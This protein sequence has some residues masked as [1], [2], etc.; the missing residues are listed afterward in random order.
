MKTS[1]KKIIALIIIVSSITACGNKTE[2]EAAT[3]KTEVTNGEATSTFKVWGNC[4]MC[5]ETIE[6]SLKVE[7]ITKADWNVDSKIITVTYDTTKITLDQIQ[8]NIASVG[9]D[10]EKYKGDDKAYNEL[11][12]CCQYDR[13]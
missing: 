4:E 13:K 2:S 6:G 8:K 1:I 7:G 11:A 5:K 12:G 10:N 9:Y 3:T